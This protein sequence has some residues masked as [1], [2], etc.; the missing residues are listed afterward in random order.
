MSIIKIIACVFLIFTGSYS[1]YRSY[2]NKKSIY[3][4]PPSGTYLSKKIFGKHFDR[5]HNFFWG[6]IFLAAGLAVF[7]DLFF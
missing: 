1:L 2:K 4:E 5:W 3:W 6:I 7:V